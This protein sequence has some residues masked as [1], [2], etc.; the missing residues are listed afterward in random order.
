MRSSLLYD[1]MATQAHVNT[2]FARSQLKKF[3]GLIVMRLRLR[4][5][6]KRANLRHWTPAENFRRNFAASSLGF[7]RNRI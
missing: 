6:P 1:S 7:V 5:R 3:E 2:Y 4:L